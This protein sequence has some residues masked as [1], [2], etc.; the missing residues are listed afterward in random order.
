MKKIIYALLCLLILDSGLPVTSFALE[1]FNSEQAAQNSCPGDKV[2]WL[3]IPTSVY[4]YRHQRW[5]GQTK[6]G[7]YVCE[8]DA[9]KS[10]KRAS[11]RG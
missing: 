1:Q 10:G 5:Y 4:H 6:H 8:K 3:N 11:K 7:A 2:V 9:I